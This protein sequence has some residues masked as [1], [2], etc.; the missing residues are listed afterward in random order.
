MDNPFETNLVDFDIVIKGLKGLILAL[1][2]SFV[3]SYFYWRNW[4]FLQWYELF[5]FLLIFNFHYL[6]NKVHFQ[7]SLKEFTINFLLAKDALTKLINARWFWHRDRAF[8]ETKFRYFLYENIEGKSQSN[9]S[10]LQS[11]QGSRFLWQVGPWNLRHCVIGE[12][13]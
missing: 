5:W 6:T 1:S 13:V 7:F 12:W 8:F 2:F 4:F 3:K 9:L 11:K 10:S